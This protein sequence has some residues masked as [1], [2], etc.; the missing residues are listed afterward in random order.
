M[1]FTTL[2]AALTFLAATTLATS[3]LPSS[4]HIRINTEARPAI[5]KSRVSSTLARSPVEAAEAVK[6]ARTA[7]I[8]NAD[9]DALHYLSNAI[10]DASTSATK[11]RG[12]IRGMS[13]RG[14]WVAVVEDGQRR[15]ED[16]VER[17][18]SETTGR[19]SGMGRAVQVRQRESRQQQREHERGQRRGASYWSAKW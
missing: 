5:V 12:E 14:E 6:V 1:Q 17:S 2:L 16:K 11:S 13:R 15:S 10:R 8:D 4:A 9:Q 18:N 3:P 19:R 7:A